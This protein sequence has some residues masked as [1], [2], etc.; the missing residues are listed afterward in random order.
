MNKVLST[1]RELPNRKWFRICKEIGI[2]LFVFA[3]TFVLFIIIYA[4]LGFAPFNPSGHLSLMLD[5]RDQYL[6]YLRYYQDVLKNHTGSLIYS[7]SKVFG[8]DFMS[9]FTY[10]LA[11]PFNLIVGLLAPA[12][13]PNFFLF[14]SIAKLS[15][16]AMNFYLLCRVY[17]GRHR[18]IY[19]GFAAAFGLMSYNVVYISNFMYMD[20]IMALPL[21]ILGITLLEKQSKHYYLYPLALFYCLWTSWY[22]GAMVCIFSVA[23]FLVRVFYLKNLK[24]E[25]LPFVVR[26][27]A[28]SLLAGLLSGAIWVT[29]FGH[30]EG[31]KATSGMPKSE[32]YPLTLF[33]SG[34]LENNYHSQS[35]ISRNEGYMTMFVGMAP[36]VFGLLFFANR[37][38]R[39]R[40]RLAE[41]VLFSILL[42]SSLWSLPYAL[43]HGGRMPSW[44]PTRFSFLTGFLICFLAAKSADRLDDT[45]KAGLLLPL[46]AL[47]VVLPVVIYTDNN[48]NL[49]GQ[50]NHYV[51]SVPSLVLY[52]LTLALVSA[53]LLLKDR[54]FALPALPY[55][56]IGLSAGVVFLALF[57]SYRGAYDVVKANVDHGSYYSSSVY[58][59]D[60]ALEP[61]FDYVKG[62]EES[63]AYRMEA[64][65]NRP[66]GTNV[67]NNNPLF[68]G[69]NGLNH[70]SSSEKKNVS[71]FM[72]N[73]GFHINSFYETYD[74]GSTCAINSYLGV[75]YLLDDYG[76]R[77]DHGPLFER[78]ANPANPYQRIKGYTEQYPLYRND[79]A[80]PLGFV[81]DK[82]NGTYVSQG[83]KRE[84]HENIYWYDDF[85]Y[86][87]K[88]YSSMAHGVKDGTGKAK[89]IFHK[90]D[91]IYTV[92]SGVTF[93]ENEW[94]TRF[95]TGKKGSKVYIDFTLPEA[96]IG[97]NIYVGVK[98]TP[99]A[100]S[101]QVDGL[102]Y[103]LNDY[104]YSGIKGVADTS[105][106][107][108]RFVITFTKDVRDAK[109]RDE[110]YYEDLDVLTE[111]LRAI[112][113]GGSMDLR[114][115]GSVFSYGFEGT[116]ELEA[117]D[118]EFLFTIPYEKEIHIYLDG[119]EKEL[120]KR[121]DIFSAISLVGEEAG[122]HSVKI[123]YVDRPFRI[124]VASTV[125]GILLAVPSFY[126]S[127]RIDGSAGRGEVFRS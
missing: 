124:G 25:L 3:L 28:L 85:E 79:L 96:A 41:G 92:S 123:V 13:I 55:M 16:G 22:L 91:A 35:S 53:Y 109:L 110:I 43:W 72:K 56:K 21:V 58:V 39:K 48:M 17:F 108:H 116:F 7:L 90:I 54:H 119:Q 19:V 45:H 18:L 93:T 120:L 37:A 75:K 50:E 49:V 14:S 125:A 73:L 82:Q 15:F 80:L 12:D 34:L 71:N 47:A 4:S 107:T 1:Y 27:A 61:F 127:A 11:S 105:S 20:V 64:T 26:F 78:N 100:F 118:K 33:F 77:G 5:Q 6:S 126:L 102:T 63:N 121:F 52:L 51:V 94:G 113:K 101:F 32:W 23:F 66:G 112:Q 103:R 59:K 44:F 115:A 95:Y 81:T 117:G 46:L 31:T 68:Y 65:F 10:Y 70:Y 86:Q 38:Y 69:Y 87:N 24:K 99:N 9:I 74:G 122:T 40:E 76:K 30:F 83:E 62:L 2:P 67:I 84:G 104:F 36:L 114:S 42:I 97:N 89:K 8:G 88:I 57:S 106:H 29:A 98:D 60:C 111:Y